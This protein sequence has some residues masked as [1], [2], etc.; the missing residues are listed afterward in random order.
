MLPR[1]EAGI[2]RLTIV[3]AEQFAR[4]GRLAEGYTCVLRALTETRRAVGR[5]EPWGAE[6]LTHYL[7]FEEHYI[8]RYGVPMA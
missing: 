5:G 1:V 3:M 2:M 8:T 6:L 7:R 4:E